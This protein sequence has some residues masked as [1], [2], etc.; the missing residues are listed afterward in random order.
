VLQSDNFNATWTGGFVVV[1]T[2]GVV[3]PDGAF[4]QNLEDNSASVVASVT[5]T[6]TIPANTDSYACSIRAHKTDHSS[7]VVQF[8]IALTGG[9]QATKI[10][11][12]DLS[13]GSLAAGAGSAEPDDYSVIDEGSWWRIWLTATNNGSSTGM[14]VT[15][16][17]SSE[18]VGLVGNATIG[19]VQVEVGTSPT[20]Y[21]PTTTVAG[22]RGAE[23]WYAPY[24]H[25]PS[26]F[27]A[28]GATLYAKWIERGTRALAIA[29]TASKRYVAL[30]ESTGST[31]VLLYSGTSGLMRALHGNGTNS[32]DQAIGSGTFPVFGDVAEMVCQVYPD[33]SVQPHISINGAAVVSGARG[34]TPV[35]FASAWETP[36]IALNSTVNGTASG[37]AAFLAVTLVPGVKT[38]AE[39]RAA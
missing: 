25:A 13:D 28:E 32:S 19:D 31:R 18:S 3:G 4:M 7:N 30:G 10:V 26:A 6:L 5:Q 1:T 8:A 17:P 38:L 24:P 29:E 14:T 27:A 23:T 16:A 15:I 21:I 33:G 35:P 34:G 20:D 37:A 9:G 12:L 2:S 11:L 36:N 39:M 22:T